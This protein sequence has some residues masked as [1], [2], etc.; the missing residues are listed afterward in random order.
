MLWCLPCPRGK[1]ASSKLLNG[2][3][4]SE[5]SWSRAVLDPNDMLCKNVNNDQ[6]RYAC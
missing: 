4:P 2:C 6:Q 5:S 1:L 3:P